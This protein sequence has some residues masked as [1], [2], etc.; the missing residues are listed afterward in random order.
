MIRP[1][2]TCLLLMSAIGPSLFGHGGQYTQPGRPA[3]VGPMTGV[4]PEDAGRFGAGGSG[5]APSVTPPGALARQ[6]AGSGEDPFRA[7]WRRQSAT[8]VA[9]RGTGSDRDRRT[10]AAA[11][12]WGPIESL[13]KEALGDPQPDVVDSALLARARTTSVDRTGDAF[14]ELWPYVAHPVESIRRSALLSLGV[15][16]SDRAT[17][18][19]LS[20]L[21]GTRQTDSVTNGVAAIA[22]GIHSD[23]IAIAALERAVE[24]APDEDVRQGAIVALGLFERGSREAFLALMG[25]LDSESLPPAA[26]ALVPISI[27]R[28]GEIAA[29]AVPP[30]RRIARRLHLRPTPMQR[31]CVIA[32][33]KLA[34]PDDRETLELLGWI[35]ANHLDAATR[36]EAW[37][38]RG[39]IAGRFVAG[40]TGSCADEERR[41]LVNALIVPKRRVD[42]PWCAVAAARSLRD[43]GA[44]V[45][46]DARDALE[47]IVTRERSATT[48]GAAALALGLLDAKDVAPLLRVTIAEEEDPGAAALVAAALGLLGD[49]A[50]LPLLRDRATISSPS[51]LRDAA[52]AAIGLISPEFATDLFRRSF[53]QAITVEERIFAALALGRTGRTAAVPDLVR[54]AKDPELDSLS[55]GF[56]IV[57]IGLILE[58]RGRS[59]NARLSDGWN[60]AIASRPVADL[61]SIF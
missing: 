7:W 49:E 18:V 14:A 3:P 5:V 10:R 20:F 22:L 16:G 42:L 59:W 45:Q 30:L 35:C 28:L 13:L 46:S 50:A 37:L 25:W 8:L 39:E 9:G 17:P 36:G 4:R 57:A 2:T 58:R 33:G 55:R 32:L 43:A 60:D 40:S 15:L 29:P 56:S 19:L 41:A 52:A 24:S 44:D 51:E 6:T 31:S 34:S 27:A 48:R 38:A 61:L 54:A 21:N 53:A 26:A 11:S 47:R 1:A 23:P 12:Q